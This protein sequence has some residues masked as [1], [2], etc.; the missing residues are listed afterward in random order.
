MTVDF[1]GF[2]EKTAYRNPVDKDAPLFK[3]AFK[4]DQLYFDYMFSPGR[5]KL[6]SAF[7]KHMEFKTLGKKWYEVVPVDQIFSDFKADDKDAVLLVDI[8]GDTGLDALNFHKTWPKLPGRIVLQDL[9]EAIEKLDKK[10][11]EPVESMGYD[12]FTPQPIKGAKAYCLKMV[13]HN[14]S[15]ES[16]QKVL[17]NIKLAMEKGYSRILINEPLIQDQ[18]AD[19][20][21][22][23]MDLIMMMVFSSHERTA[24]GWKALIEAVEGLKVVKIWNCEGVPEK[25]IEVEL[26]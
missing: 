12:F 16:C 8:G 17:A 4:T 23:S 2:L 24:R 10:A 1:P 25:L 20:F 14:W 5:E 26:V 21:S 13:L 15:D 19:W 22:T 6:A 9:P 11:L 7:S 18:H 3:Y